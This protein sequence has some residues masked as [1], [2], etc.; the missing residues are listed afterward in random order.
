MSQNNRHLYCVLDLKFHTKSGRKYTIYEKKDSSLPMKLVCD[1]KIMA[2]NYD[3][4]PQRYNAFII[5]IC[6]QL[7][8]YASLMAH[9]FRNQAINTNGSCEI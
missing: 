2:N 3:C 5:Q 7:G 8:R 1:S 9:A 6:L 4:N